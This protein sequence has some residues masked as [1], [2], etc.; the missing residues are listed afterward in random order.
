M[1]NE[2]NEK[3]QNFL[4]K[5]PKFKGKFHGYL[6]RRGGLG[7]TRI[8]ND[9]YECTDYLIRIDYLLEALEEMQLIKSTSDCTIHDV[10]QQSEPFVNFLDF[11]NEKYM[12]CMFPTTNKDLA[13]AY[14]KFINGG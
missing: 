6:E 4:D 1:A 10:T 12:V 9:W 3:L 11:L 5:N 14:V 13:D 2:L 7:V 8:D